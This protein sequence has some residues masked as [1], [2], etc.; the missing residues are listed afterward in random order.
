[1]T[2]NIK[3]ACTGQ[4]CCHECCLFRKEAR[5]GVTSYVRVHSVHIELCFEV[6]DEKI[7]YGLRDRLTT[8]T[9]LW[10][11]ATGHLIMKRRQTRPL[12]ESWK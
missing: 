5:S 3:I 10:V 7:E 1:M 9:V 11:F 6:A 8:V 2:A 4:E 12:T